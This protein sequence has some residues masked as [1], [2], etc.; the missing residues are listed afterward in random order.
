MTK[1]HDV[2]DEDRT[3]QYVVAGWL[4]I[5]SRP[6]TTSIPPQ[7]T[8]DWSSKIQRYPGSLCDSNTTPF[9]VPVLE[10]SSGGG[11]SRRS[12]YH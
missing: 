6:G 8:R 9:R 7:P 10:S 12:G 2:F 11:R 3:G 1:D 5:R 4:S